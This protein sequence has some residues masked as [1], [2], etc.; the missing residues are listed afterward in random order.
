MYAKAKIHIIIFII[1]F[2]ITTSLSNYIEINT[3]ELPYKDPFFIDNKGREWLLTRNRG[4]F[5]IQENGKLKK[6]YSF[7]DT[8]LI[9]PRVYKDGIILVSEN[10][11]ILNFNLSNYTLRTLFTLNKR[12]L[13]ISEVSNNLMGIVTEDYFVRLLD[14]TNRSL[15]TLGYVPGVSLLS[16]EKDSLS[17]YYKDKIAR[18][19]ISSK[20]KSF[21]GFTNI[22]SSEE[23]IPFLRNRV[24]LFFKNSEYND[25]CFLT[26]LP[27]DLS[28]P[29][30]F[31]SR[32]GLFFSFPEGKILFFNKEKTNCINSSYFKKFNL[33]SISVSGEDCYISFPESN[34]KLITKLEQFPSER[35]KEI[36]LEDID[37]DN[38]KDAIFLFIANETLYYY[39]ILIIF[40]SGLVQEFS[41]INPGSLSSIYKDLDKDSVKELIL[42]KEM[43]INL[44]TDPAKRLLIPEVYRYEK[45][46][47]F[48]WASIYYPSFYEE[49]KKKIIKRLS[50][51]PFKSNLKNSIW[52]EMNSIIIS[53]MTEL[54][55]LNRQLN[56][57]NAR[58]RT[59]REKAGLSLWFYKKGLEMFNNR[60][61]NIA[62]FTFKKA[63]EL[64]PSNKRAAFQAERIY[65]EYGFFDLSLKIIKNPSFKNIVFIQNQN[66][67][68]MKEDI[69]PVLEDPDLFY[70]SFNAGEIYFHMKEYKKAE[71]FFQKCISEATY[72][73]PLFIQNKARLLLAECHLI[74][75][76]FT[77]A[78]REYKIIEKNFPGEETRYKLN[79]VQQLIKET[80]TD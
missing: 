49:E 54:I 13:A 60:W 4:L 37:K 34:T 73:H 58:P 17:V 6:E 76:N 14:L 3:G 52:K 18:F 48:I 2:K 26:E 50:V 77:D 21:Q 55:T 15:R 40:S 51:L 39:R 41:T 8:F 5:S 38:R 80:K 70:Q 64:D 42:T 25:W 66:Y 63:L 43:N 32:E 47:G 74:M 30:F 75:N 61:D 10:G 62:L 9:P 23:D 72:K 68:R 45:N 1:F 44:D 67:Y 29:S 69:F 46:S 24:G 16:I 56:Q 11:S 79:L 36:I 31:K 57:I 59:P 27:E 7:S 22:L 35:L 71:K 53:L 78:E 33:F 28:N 65:S 19:K 20:S 12:A